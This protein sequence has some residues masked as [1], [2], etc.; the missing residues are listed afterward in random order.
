MLDG[1]AYSRL[2]ILFIAIFIFGSTQDGNL[3]DPKP[4]ANPKPR[5]V[6]MIEIYQK[7]TKN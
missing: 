5:V 1:P 4:N 2:V 7:L 3:M 6:I